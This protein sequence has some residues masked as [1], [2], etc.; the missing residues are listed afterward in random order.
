MTASRPRSRAWPSVDIIQIMRSQTTK[1]FGPSG[2]SSSTTQSSAHHVQHDRSDGDGQQRTRR[3]LQLPERVSLHHE[4]AVVFS[5][6]ART[7]RTLRRVTE[8]YAPVRRTVMPVV[9]FH[10]SYCSK[11]RALSRSFY[12][13]G[14]VLDGE[15]YFA[16]HAPSRSRNHSAVSESPTRVAKSAALRS[17]SFTSVGS[18]PSSINNRHTSA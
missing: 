8:R 14:G 10:R 15:A 12:C 18:A 17:R 5:K 16:R 6:A 11:W 13:L 2:T 7:R 4:T 1:C 9:A 3:R